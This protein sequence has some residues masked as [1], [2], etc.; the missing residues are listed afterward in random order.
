[1]A[2]FTRALFIPVA[3]LVFSLERFA[4]RDNLDR[5]AWREPGEI[6]WRNLPG[7]TARTDL[8][9]EIAWRDLPGDLQKE[10]PFPE[11]IQC[12]PTIQAPVF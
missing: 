11:T 2:L 1:M 10:I 7:E 9:G 12:S 8:P 4:W 3:V 5:S 6:A